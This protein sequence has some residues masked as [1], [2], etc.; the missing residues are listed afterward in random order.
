MSPGRLPIH[1]P[2]QLLGTVR[3]HDRV[4]AGDR[5]VLS[6]HWARRGVELLPPVTRSVQAGNSPQQNAQPQSTPKQNTRRQGTPIRSVP[7]QAATQHREELAA[8]TD[9]PRPTPETLQPWWQEQ[10]LRPL[11]LAPAPLDMN[12]DN[13]ILGS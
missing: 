4:V 13:V 3:H 10:V 9:E 12:L 6:A 1:M 11:A 7:I 8:P 2:R 5:L